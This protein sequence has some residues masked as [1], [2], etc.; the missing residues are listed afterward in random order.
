MPVSAGFGSLVPSK[1]FVDVLADAERLISSVKQYDRT[2]HE[3]IALKETSGSHGAM[4]EGLEVTGLYLT[5]LDPWASLAFAISLWAATAT[6]NT[7]R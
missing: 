6:R 2:G 5:G 7:A 3:G 1:V 4:H